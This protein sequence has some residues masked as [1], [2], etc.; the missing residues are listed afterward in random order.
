M[1]TP[2]LIVGIGAS[3]GGLEP[4]RGLVEHLPAG[5]GLAVV[6]IQHLEA[7][8]PRNPTVDVLAGACPLRVVEAEDGMAVEADTLYVTPPGRHLDVAGGYF[9][10]REIAH[11][12]HLRMPIDHFLCTLAAQQA[13]RCCGVLL[14]GGGSDGVLGLSEIKAYGGLTI[15]QDSA[16][17]QTPEMPQHAMA[18]GVV[19]LAIKVAEMPAAILAY[20]EKVANQELPQDDEAALRGILATLKTRSGHDFR[21]Y[22]RG[23]LVRRIRRR[24]ELTKSASLGAYLQR[25]RAHDDEIAQ[26][27][28]DL[29]IGVTD[30]FRQPEAWRV[31]EEKVI[32]PLIAAA[33]AEGSGQQPSA[34]G[35]STPGTGPSEARDSFEVRATHASPLPMIEPPAATAAND[36]ARTLRIWV[37]GCATG[38][39]AYTLAMLFVEAIDAAGAKIGIQIFATDTDESSLDIARAG[40]YPEAEVKSIPPER[41]QRFFTR[42]A[43]RCH[44][45]KE[46]RDLVVF[47]QQNL[48]S[49]PPFS[50]LDLIS[51]RNLLI[52]LDPSVQKK[53]IALF[54]FALREGGYLFLGNAETIAGHEDLFDPV[55]RKWRIYR[56]IGSGRRA[57][58]EL[59]LYAGHEAGIAGRLPMPGGPAAWRQSLAYLIQQSLL[60]RFAPAA[61]IIDRRRQLLYSH[62]PV[63]RYLAV[64][65]GEGSLDLIELAREG[66]RTRLRAAVTKAVERRRSVTFTARVKRGE[67]SVPVRVTI[68]P[69]HLPR[70]TDEL[71][72]ATFEDVK[73]AAAAPAERA[74]GDAGARQLEDE[75]RVTREELQSTIEQME[76]ANE[77]LKASNEETT[78]A[79]EEL[80]SAN[81]EL[82]TSKEELQSLNEELNTVNNRLQ[83]RADELERSNNDLVNFQTSSNIGTVFLDRDLKVRRYTPAV[84]ALLSLIETDIG[85]PISDVVR[86]FKDDALISDAGTVLATLTPRSAEVP[87][88]NGCWFIR[89]ITPY[90]TRD[91]HIEGVVITF[92]DVNDLKEA[93]A[94][95]ECTVVEVAVAKDRLETVLASITDAYL[96]LDSDWRF[97]EINPV[98]ETEAFARPACELLGKIIWDVFPQAV[99]GEVYTQYQ[100]A[101]A[102]GQPVHFE[103]KSRIL[104][105]WWEIHAYPREG[106]LEVYMREITARKEAEVR[107]AYLASFPEYD[108]NPVVEVDPEGNVRYANPAALRL[109]P[110]LAERGPRHPWLADCAQAVRPLREGQAES[111]VRDVTVVGRVYQQSFYLFAPDGVVRIYGLDITERRR[112]EDEIRRHAEEL[113]VANE[114]LAIFNQVAVGRELRMVEL[115]KQV[116]D[117]YAKAGLPERYDLNFDEEKESR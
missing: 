65:P 117:L 39:E 102:S 74:A 113:R 31:I 2:I 106:R 57:A 48:T 56:R 11:C 51:C 3:S 1:P 112:A 55:S 26:L 93:Q 70:E 91:D 32:G 67:S 53:I 110:D 23:T 38:K 42:K 30:F 76:G 4:L 45:S 100:A 7:A 25:L 84:T 79:N 107:L 99:G 28:K 94:Q 81:E 22:K 90:R 14:S 52:Y 116:N 20:A 71:L 24:A 60:E 35:P 61:A 43:G 72:L 82:E 49:D 69:L 59:P 101:V 36:T 29:L 86:K 77:E 18:A 75:L 10:V 87:A 8:A 68:S 58:V 40:I 62:G 5:R 6:V 50:K 21:C 89:R 85:R 15:A 96:V 34:I 108:P 66:L 88:E 73:L 16:E 114:E 54:H 47:A 78:A 33:M 17:A 41:L 104:D 80:Q 19:D 27:R 111:A 83:E 44:V 9:T 13:H 105:K 46:I 98:A 12:D 92:V 97:V 37:P 109:F 63:D 64:A 95:L 115:K 103:A